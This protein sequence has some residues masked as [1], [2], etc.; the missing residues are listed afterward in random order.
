VG[1]ISGAVGTF[2]HL[3]PDVE[4]QVCARLGLK[5]APVSTQ[6]LQR[7]RHAEYL[8]TIAIVGAS[9]DKFATEIRHLQRTEVREAEEP[10][11]AGQKGSS[12]MP[13]KRN[14]VKCEQVSGLSRLL[15]GYAVTGLEN[16]A[17]WHERD[18]SHSSAERVILPDATGVLCYLL[19]A[20]TKIV[21]KMV[22]YP[23]RMLKNIELTRGLAYSGQ[24]LLDLTRKGVVREDAYRWI[25]RCSMK[26]WDEDKDF[27]QVLEADPDIT[28]VLSRDEIRSVVNPE[29]QLRNVDAIFAR[30]FDGR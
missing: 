9:L 1:K 25:Q 19:R 23:E 16:V 6:T 24:L 21:R 4:A 7:D 17:L 3:D 14:P 29:L 13:H 15:R 8:C 28:K 22:V 11:A 12:A 20:M 18:I 30:V 27:L 2:A 10:F 5:A 26:V